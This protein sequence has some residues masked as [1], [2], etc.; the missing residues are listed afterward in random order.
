MFKVKKNDLFLYLRLALHLNEDL[1]L[2]AV[3][4]CLNSIF[5]A[6][7]HSLEL[8]CIQFTGVLFSSF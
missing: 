1:K 6:K 3:L 2:V 8:L 5:I 4:S 7:T